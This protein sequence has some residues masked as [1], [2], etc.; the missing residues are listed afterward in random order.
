MTIATWSQR[1]RRHIASGTELLLLL[2]TVIEP[3]VV[4]LVIQRL[5]TA[6]LILFVVECD[7]VNDSLWVFLLLLLGNTICLERFLPLLRETLS[8]VSIQKLM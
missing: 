8:Y 5:I 2:R 3:G 1:S 6:L 4:E 7:H